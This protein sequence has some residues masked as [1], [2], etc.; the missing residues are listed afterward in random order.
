MPW[1]W[2]IEAVK[3]PENKNFGTETGSSFN[4]VRNLHRSEILTWTIFRKVA[5]EKES[6]EGNF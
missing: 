2:H 1:V 5:I 4:Y 3:G 6:S